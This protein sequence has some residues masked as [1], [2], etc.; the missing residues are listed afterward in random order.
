MGINTSSI[1]EK[2]FGNQ[3]GRLQC[4][5]FV[6]RAEPE[7]NNAYGHNDNDQHDQL[8]CG[9]VFIGSGMGLSA[10]ERARVREMRQEGDLSKQEDTTRQSNFNLH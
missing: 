4:D 2:S 8:Q 3:R 7:G 6:L 5:Y 10:V 1:A 9:N